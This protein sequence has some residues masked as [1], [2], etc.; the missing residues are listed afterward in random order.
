MIQITF[1]Q[2]I[3]G[4]LLLLVPCYVMFHFG[5]KLLRTTLHAWLKMVICLLVL[6]LLLYYVTLW[7]HP[8]VTLLFGLLAIVCGSALAVRRAKM[9]LQQM[10]VPVLCGMMAGVVVVGLYVL[11]LVMGQ[12]NPLQARFFIPVIGLLVGHNVVVNSQALHIYYMGLRHHA[13]LYYYLLGNGGT[14]QQAVNYLMRRAIQRAALPG[15]SNMGLVAVGLSPVMLWSMLLGGANVI[16]AVAYQAL[17]L[18]AML[19]ASVL[20]V[21]VTLTVSRRYLFDGYNR[22][23]GVD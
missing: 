1:L 20:S 16:T 12:K 2:C 18:I 17:L 6:G 5:I 7:N 10:F 9:K 3:L 22:L 11:L 15:I 4:L 14:H 19:A 8:V 21:V 23:K 13:Q